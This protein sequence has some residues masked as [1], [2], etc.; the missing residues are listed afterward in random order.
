MWI[1]TSLDMFSFAAVVIFFFNSYRCI[2]H[3]PLVIV[4]RLIL[5]IA[6]GINFLIRHDSAIPSS[7]SIVW[8][9]LIHVVSTSTNAISEL[10]IY[11]WLNKQYCSK[12]FKLYCPNTCKTIS[13]CIKQLKKK[14]NSS[15]SYLLFLLNISIQFLYKNFFKSNNIYTYTHSYNVYFWNRNKWKKI[16]YV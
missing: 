10:E 1:Q 5:K 4:M 3:V 16:N 6:N 13:A 2:N 8:A 11:M 7:I 15:L 12:Q 14:R 9:L